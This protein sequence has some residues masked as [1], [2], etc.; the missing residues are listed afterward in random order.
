[1]NTLLESLIILLLIPSLAAC[2]QPVNNAKTQTVKIDGNCGMCEETIEGAAFIK[3]VAK[4]DWNKDTKTAVITFDSTQTTVDDILKRIAFA[5]YDN[6]KYLAPSEAYA[7]LPECCQYTRANKAV[8][9]EPA[10]ETNAAAMYVCPMH[11]EVTSDKPGSCPKCHMALVKQEA[12]K[13]EAITEHH[14]IK[15]EEENETPPQQQA[16]PLTDVFNAYFAI[17][18]ALIQSDGNT[19]SAKAKELFKAIDAVKMESLGKGQHTAWMKYMEKLSYDAGH[20]RDTRDAEH[21][22]QHFVTLSAN[23]YE[24]IKVSKPGYTV[25]YDNC[26]MYNDNKGANWLSKE[27]GIKNPYYGSQMLT[28]GKT[29]ETIK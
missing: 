24:V 10:Q 6:E 3:K 16:E 18:D 27:T 8:E 9:K 25:Y 15:K 22:R 26:P 1:M 28:C 11:P 20:I 2:S 4:A 13:T 14:H 7:K 19:A 12:T 29:V 17:K 23:M 5:G 21:Q